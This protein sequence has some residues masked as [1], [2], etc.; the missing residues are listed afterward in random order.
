MGSTRAGAGLGAA[1]LLLALALPTHARADAGSLDLSSSMSAACVGAGGNSDCSALRF[2]LTLENGDFWVDFVRLQADEGSAWR[3]AT[4]GN[5]VSVEDADG[6][7]LQGWNATW[8]SNAILL[9]SSGQRGVEPIYLVVN[10]TNWGVGGVYEGLS[11]N[12]S[13]CVSQDCLATIYNPAT[14]LDTRTVSFDGTVTP[15]PISMVLLG[16]GLLGVGGVAR[17]RKN[18]LEED[19]EA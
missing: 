7:A 15:E 1:A 2:E 3:F 13:G 6:N 4:I 14:G 10:M 8:D 18:L 11:Y 9:A 5:P 19:E 16:S 12:G 17:R